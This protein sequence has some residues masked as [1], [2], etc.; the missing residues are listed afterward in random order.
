MKKLAQITLTIGVTVLGLFLLWVFRDALALFGGSL[1]IS[2]ALRPLVQEMERRGIGRGVAILIWYLLILAGLIV[3]GLIYGLRL[4]NEI[5]VGTEQLPQLYDSTRAAWQHGT[6]LQ[7]TIARGLPDFNGLLQSGAS[8]E[9]ATL[10]SGTVAGIAGSVLGDLVFLFAALSLAY[11]WLME[12]THF[13]RLWLSLLPVSARVRA[14]DIW[15]NAEGAVGT[16]IRA[17]VVAIVIAGL[18]LL[19]LYSLVQLPFAAMLALLG[20]FVQIVPR[21]GPVLGLLPAFLVALMVSPLEA[22]IVLVGGIAIQVFAHKVA[23][24]LMHAEAVKVN[25]LLQVLLLLALA[26]LSGFWAMIYAPPLAALIHVLYASLLAN[27]VDRQPQESAFERLI[28]RLDDLQ[29]ASS[30]A[31]REISSILQRSSSL[32]SQARGLLAG[33]RSYDQS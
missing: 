10:I 8:G 1:A 21:L 18:L 19:A 29:A 9:G 12:V 27:N 5:A 17:T 25:P 13:E 15:R 28:E 22:L 32:I 14:R 31:P 26:D 4:T 2:A 33:G 3:G 11:Y 23:V 24:R 30:P 6:D 16:Y 20:G 7:Q